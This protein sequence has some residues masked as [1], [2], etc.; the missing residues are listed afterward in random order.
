MTETTSTVDDVLAKLQAELDGL[1]IRRIEAQQE[2]NACVPRMD[3]L[4]QRFSA[5][6]VATTVLAGL[7]PLDPEQ[8][9]LDR[10]TAWRQTLRDE[11]LTLPPRIRSDKDLGRQ[12][13]LTLSIRTIE[14]GIGAGKDSGYDLTNLRL[15][16]LMREA[17]YEPV[18]ADPD[19]NFSGVMPWFGSL[20]EVQRRIA[21]LQKQRDD[22]QA[23]LDEALLDD[24]ARERL[25]AEGKA[26]RDALNAAPQRKVRGD[27]SE[28]DRYPDGRVVEVSL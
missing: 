9:W 26:R 24:D 12:Q 21:A 2:A 19:R 22:A 6:Q 16:H 25:A 28:Y 17:G 8:E 18:G 1:N 5:I 13:N 23:R 20:P 14:F 4:R 3:V 10:L 15:G 11:L 27:G 7:A